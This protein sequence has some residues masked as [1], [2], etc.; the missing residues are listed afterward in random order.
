MVYRHNPY[1][2]EQSIAQNYARHSKA[3]VA[4][5]ELVDKPA[6]GQLQQ[7]DGY[8]YASVSL[9]D[10]DGFVNVLK[11]MGDVDGLYYVSCDSSADTVY[12]EQTN[13]NELQ[14]LRLIKA[15]KQHNQGSR[16]IDSYIVSIDNYTLDDSRNDCSGAG[17]TGL[18]YSLAQGNY[19]FKVRNVDLSGADLAS[20]QQRG[21]TLQTML[22]LPASNRGDVVKLSQG[23][24]Y[25][26]AFLKVDWQMPP[27]SRLAQG[28]VYVI[29]GGSGTVGKIFTANL[30]EQYDAKVVWIG[31]SSKDDERIASL[32]Q[33]FNASNQLGQLD[34]VQADS[35]SMESMK[36][37][38]AD[39]IARHGHITGAIFGGMVFGVED[40]IDQTTESQFNHIVGIKTQGSRIFYEVMADLPLDFMV[41][42]SSGQA[43]SFSGAARLSG[44]ATGITFSDSYVRSLR[45]GATFPVG[46]INWGFWRDSVEQKVKKLDSVSTD[47]IAALDGQQGFDCFERFVDALQQGKLSQVLCMEVSSEVHKLMNIQQQPRKLSQLSGVILPQATERATRAMPLPVPAAPVTAAPVQAISAPAPVDIDAKVA[48]EVSNALARTLQMEQQ[49]LELDIA[50]SD[51]GI[52]S[53][54]GATFV[55]HING[56]LNIEL[57]TAVIF[58]Y[59]NIERL[60]AHIV[61]EFAEQLKA[62]FQAT[63]PAPAAV[64]APAPVLAP[65]ATVSASE[66]VP[67]SLFD[68]L[69]DTLSIDKHSIETDIAFSDYGID[70]IL[71][72]SFVERINSA[73][74]IELNTAVIFEYASIDALSRHVVAEYGSQIESQLNASKASGAPVATTVT[75]PIATPIATQVGGRRL[76]AGTKKA[77]KA[78]FEYSGGQQ[79]LAE[80]AI[81]AMSGQFPKANDIEQFWQN[82]VTGVDGVDELPADYLDQ[83]RFYDSVK[84]PGKT[85]CKWG[86]IVSERDCFDPLFFN[87]SPKEAESMNPHQRLIMQESYKAL[88]LAGY[89]P[90][91]LAGSLTGIFVGAE[92]A[93]YVGNSFTGLSDAIVASR[94]S[95]VLD[96]NG[97]AFAVNTGCSASAV[98]IHLACESL[99][100]GE[101]TMALAGG[102]NTCMAQHIQVRLDEI[103]MLSPSGRCFTFDERGDGTIISEAVA[104]LVLKKLDDAIEDDDHIHGV[105]CASGINQDGASNGITAPSGSAQQRLICE[106]YDRFGI[107]PEHIG[108]VEAHGTGTKLGDP[109]ETNALVRAFGKYTDKKAYCAVGSAKSHIGHAAAAAGVV[110]TIK[111]LLS[112]RHDTLPKLLNFETLNPLI[113]FAGSPFFVNDKQ[114]SWPQVGEGVK[115]AAINSFG[116][117][118]TNAHL[119]VREYRP[120]AQLTQ[121]RVTNE[122]NMVLLSAKTPEQLLQKAKDLLNFVNTSDQRVDLTSLAY[123][124]QVAREPMSER[125]AFSCRSMAQLQQHLGAVIDANA[126]LDGLQLDGV[127]RGL[128][129][130]NNEMQYRQDAQLQQK[131]NQ[132]LL[133]SNQNHSNHNELL[134]LWVN[135]LSVNWQL[136]YEGMTAHSRPKRIELPVYPFAKERYWIDDFVEQVTSTLKQPRAAGLALSGDITYSANG[137]SIE[138]VIN[139]LDDDSLDISEGVDLLKRLI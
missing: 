15:L 5:L 19:Q 24:T 109:I 7:A 138:Q 53:I 63:A 100:S 74:G 139:Q 116:H 123:T 107:N 28:G 78:A 89:N 37:A 23:E 1:G 21:Q 131:V 47:N 56:A 119:V 98:A 106:V 45:L 22:R 32:L 64:S 44:Y 84:Q 14:L 61:A 65:V 71:G 114:R 33:Q 132:W 38:V 104:M 101:S 124:L 67:A 70:S 136:P 12:T 125:L 66:K 40:S 83:A 122:V 121:A 51:Y 34:Y 39:I 117:S 11:Q 96:L 25:R 13:S 115:M 2:F 8:D 9:S 43:Y 103:D 94:L 77:T 55:E 118:G 31:R 130:R 10:S 36:A 16:R 48:I 30:I 26:Q 20:A 6:K 57:N 75:T 58:E 85:R 4:L 113:E 105:I 50:F 76:L 80:I 18:G 88:E 27:L 62:Q 92:P 73:L 111:V 97:P 91:D 86:G 90:R 46:T 128:A 72:A 108:Y 112:M 93:G 81:I 68:C 59:A 52:D 82:L 49:A 17:A 134:S 29:V 135:G 110:G 42:F 95:Y 87:I 41:F 99:R 120:Q 126:E 102:A 60:S 54:L 129:T 79:P 35:T 3:K 127:Y 133:E 137:Q 69:A